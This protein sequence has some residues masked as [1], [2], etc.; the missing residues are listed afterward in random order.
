[1]VD[2]PSGS[3]AD[4]SDIFVQGYQPLKRKRHC[5]K[6][7][8]SDCAGAS[9]KDYC[10]NPCADCNSLTCPGRNSARPTK[11]CKEG[12]KPTQ[13]SKGKQRMI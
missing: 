8:F 12:W 9:S 5:M 1:M 6:C 3:V 10:R 4:H 13:R 7:G 2:T 11:D